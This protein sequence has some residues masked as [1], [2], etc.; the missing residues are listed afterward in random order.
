MLALTADCPP[1]AIAAD[2]RRRPAPAVVHAGWRGLLAGSSRPR[3]RPSATGTPRWSGRRSARAATRSGPMCGRFRAR[4]GADIVA[5]R[6]SRPLDGSGGR[7]LDAGVE[8][9]E[10]LDLCTACHP[11]LFFSERR[12]GGHAAPGCDRPCRLSD[13]RRGYER[14]REEVGPAVTIVAA[15]KYVA[16]RGHGGRSPR[17]GSRS[18]ARTAR[19]TSRRSTPP[20]ATPSAG[21]SSGTCRSN[22]AK[23]VNRICELV[24]SLD[25]DSAA[26]RLE[27]PALVQVNLAGE[28][29]KSGVSPAEL[30][31]CS[32]LP[33]VPVSRRCRPATGTPR[34]RARTSGGC[35]SWPASTG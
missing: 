16:R 6:Q 32:A 25:S 18:W 3:W 11:G 21:T 12:T 14:V 4:F 28:E 9:V 5:R 30:P 24:H 15:T 2:E 23:V 10:R 20:T 1:I 22:K 31:E 7:A 29:S 33:G 13:P 27:V 34:T 19:R 35:A 8:R 17:P 26:R